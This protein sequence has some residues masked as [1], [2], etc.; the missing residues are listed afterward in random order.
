MES[1][2]QIQMKQ[3]ILSII[4]ILCSSFAFSQELFEYDAESQPRWSS[5][6][7]P[8]AEK[9]E[10]G[11]ENYGA[12][13]SAHK[14][15]NPGQEVELLNYNG[16]GIIQRIWMT[17]NKRSP[18]FLRAVKLEMYWDG[19]NKPA[20]SVP[21]G[22]FFGAGTGK[23][24]PF[25]SALFADP[26][27]RSFITYIPMPFRESAKIVL[28]NESEEAIK[29]FYDV[30]FTIQESLPEETLYFHAYWHRENPTT[31]AEDFEV[32]PKVEG[33]GRF[34][35]TSI[36]IITD[37]IY[38]GAWW[39]EGEIKIY[40]DGDGKYPTLVGTGTEDYI[41][42]A[43]G[44]GTYAHQYSG[45]IIASDNQWSFYRFHIP[46]PI[47][48]SEEIRVTLQQMGGAM[49]KQY[50]KLLGR[51][52]PLIPVT[53]ENLVTHEL[54]EL[55]KKDIEISELDF[56]SAWVNFF[57]QDDVSATAY[58]YLDKPENNLPPLPSKE[59]RIEGMKK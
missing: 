52:A 10:G 41:G 51:N 26:E 56:S 15:I 38:D 28:T 48:F 34:L 17:I 4:L 21:I 59:K 39:G 47:Y 53:L 24:V 42:T 46:D 19:A 23:K 1:I 54:V 29:F 37:S 40:L 18:S 13:G 22:D 12:K 16:T 20:V 57:R 14:W 8:S 45:S 31:L 36:G 7:N 6:E 25:E 11:K 49:H 27:G 35:G 5:F 9:G 43:W 3:I 32:L 44:Q 50:Q 2:Q 58:F 55:Y 30:N 33:K